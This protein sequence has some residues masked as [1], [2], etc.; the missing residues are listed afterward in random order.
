[1]PAPSTR[2]P[3]KRPIGDQKVSGLQTSFSGIN[4]EIVVLIPMF[5]D[6]QVIYGSLV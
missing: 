6:V 1:M 2:G 3:V 5:S 4:E